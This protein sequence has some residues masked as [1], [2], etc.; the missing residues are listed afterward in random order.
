MNYILKPL[1]TQSASENDIDPYS[2]QTIDMNPDFPETSFP[3]RTYS[4]SSRRESSQMFWELEGECGGGMGDLMLRSRKGEV[5]TRTWLAFE[6][7]APQDFP[8]GIAAGLIGHVINWGGL[9][10]S[11]GIGI[12]SIQKRF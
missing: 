9:R 8:D 12:S 10:L 3:L 4:R 6:N 11:F 1:L 2:Q 5:I 7:Q